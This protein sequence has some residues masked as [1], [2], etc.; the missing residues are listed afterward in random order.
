MI[1]R[2]SL[3][4]LSGL[5]SVLLYKFPAAFPKTGIPG[6]ARFFFIIFAFI[7][8]GNL[9]AAETRD[10]Y[11]RLLINE[12][13]GGFSLF[14]LADSEKM[15]YEPLFNHGNSSTSFIDVNVNGT[16]YRPGKS[17][18]FKISV[19]RLEK[20]PS[21]VF[22]SDFLHISEVFTPVKTTGSH[23]ANG[24]KINI[25]VTN[26]GGED[27][28]AGLRFL[29]DTYL[30][31]GR[32]QIPFVT[33]SQEITSETI[34][35]NSDELYWV[36]R[37]ARAS[38]MGNIVSP[39]ESVS[40]SPDYLHFANWNILSEAPWKPEFREGRSF[41]RLPYS[42]RD[43]AV[44][45][46]WEPD[47]LPPGQSFTYTVYLTTEDIAWYLPQAE[48]VLPAAQGA[49]V[50]ETSEPAVSSAGLEEAS[51]HFASG[52][53]AATINI[54]PIEDQASV[55]SEETGENVNIITLRL[56]RNI[57]DE[58]IRGEIMLNEQDLKLIEM[59]F[60]KHSLLID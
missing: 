52:I 44:C 26:T 16:A 13:T 57:L 53:E 24:V 17:R 50:T 22:E 9:S 11:I 18:D 47:T 35:R 43:S 54:E 27:I 46:Y 5:K 51:S 58:F 20:N 21:I 38:L 12:K 33:E 14:Y 56:L 59:T 28:E 23:T 7:C 8:L 6:K 29:I 1:N 60:E 42:V 41:S 40:K 49:E 39:N 45:Y 55:V 32:R 48:N 19:G 10:R 31:E 15:R 3:K 4:N 2:K 34:I 36:S 37:G 30:G 25:T